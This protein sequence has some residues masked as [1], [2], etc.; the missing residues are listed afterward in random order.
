MSFNR[1]IDTH[2]LEQTKN[3][4]EQVFGPSINL[5]DI[6]ELEKKINDL[7]LSDIENL[8]NNNNIFNNKQI[9][10]YNLIHHNIKNIS[11]INDI[12]NNSILTEPNLI[13][14]NNSSV[15]HIESKD[16][17]SENMQQLLLL[18]T[19]VTKPVSMKE[20]KF[21]GR[22]KKNDESERNYDIKSR[23]ARAKLA[24]DIITLIKG[25]RNVW[26]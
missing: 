16:S 9:T 10:K 18:N 20:N 4:T 8:F 2:S 19:P 13:L 15:P 5:F 17:N 6:K 11:N 23:K 3:N 14:R 7:S 25:G 1:P 22:K 24:N 21:L 26:E 12:N